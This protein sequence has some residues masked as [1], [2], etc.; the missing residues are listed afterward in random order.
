RLG[1]EES[2]LRKLFIDLERT[3]G[4]L[5][6]AKIGLDGLNNEKL[7]CVAVQGFKPLD[8]AGKWANIYLKYGTPVGRAV[9]FAEIAKDGLKVG[10]SGSDFIEKSIKALRDPSL[11]NFNET[12]VKFTEFVTGITQYKGFLKAYFDAA[13][14]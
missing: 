12:Y 9:S 6:A 8:D 1:R 4:D 3:R 10:V 14:L 5:E 11:K 7:Y 13:K 2:D